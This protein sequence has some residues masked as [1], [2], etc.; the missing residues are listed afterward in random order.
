MADKKSEL[1][2]VKEMLDAYFNN[3]DLS[4]EVAEN[5][6]RW[7]GRWFAVAKDDD[8]KFDMLRDVFDGMVEYEQN[9]DMQTIRTGLEK[10]CARLNMPK[11]GEPGYIALPADTPRTVVV[12][13]KRPQ[14]HKYNAREARERAESQLESMFGPI[15]DPPRR[16]TLTRLMAAAAIVVVMICGVLFYRPEPTGTADEAAADNVAMVIKS[17]P[18]MP[19]AHDCTKLP[20]GS[21]VWVNPGSTIGMPEDFS[22]GSK[23]RIAL[24]DGEVY[25]SVAKDSLR[26]FVVETGRLAVNVIGTRFNVKS[27]ADKQQIIVTLFEGQV[28]VDDTVDGKNIMMRPGQRL[29]YDDRTGTYSIEPTEAYLPDWV[30]ERLDFQHLTLDGIFRRMEWYYGIT[31]DNT[32]LRNNDIYSFRLSGREDLPTALALV[33]FITHDFTS[34]ISGDTVT[35][36]Q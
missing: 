32:A 28:R 14:V 8:P 33:E 11:P 6:L 18:D 22:A 3:P 13:D 9:P 30:E 7:I 36:I 25:L 10:L 26:P 27:A 12:S 34:R 17:I 21:R 24:E 2:K 35:I 23:R 5:M 15:P 4:E 16:L 29:I 31:I 19:D 20:D 1:I